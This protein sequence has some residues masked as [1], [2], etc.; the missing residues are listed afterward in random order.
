[1]KS[2]FL[3]HKNEIKYKD[4]EFESKV[5]TPDGMKT[6]KHI[7]TI[8]GIGNKAIKYQEDHGEDEFIFYDNR[9]IRYIARVIIKSFDN[10]LWNEEIRACIEAQ[11]K[12]CEDNKAPH[13]APEDGFCYSCGKQI[14][15]DYHE[16]GFTDRGKSI[17]YASTELITG[18]PHCHRSYCD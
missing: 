15:T 10:E 9:D 11:K 4:V 14:Y 13:F 7:Y 5:W 12:Y 18:C 1:M 6:E 2:F 8:T 17:E 16:H 3:N